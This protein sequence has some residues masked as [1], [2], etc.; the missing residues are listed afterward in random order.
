MVSLHSAIN[1][2]LLDQEISERCDGSK[3]WKKKQ[4]QMTPTPRSIIHIEKPQQQHYKSYFTVI[5]H[6]LPRKVD[7]FQ[8]R[9]F[10]SK[11]GKVSKAKVRCKKKTSISKALGN[12]TMAMIEEQADAVATLDGLVSVYILLLNY[13]CFQLS[14]YA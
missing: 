11:H 6:N 8:L 1:F 14:N 12:M 2:I 5:V 9:R 4:Q 7:N 3:W 10:F 13:G